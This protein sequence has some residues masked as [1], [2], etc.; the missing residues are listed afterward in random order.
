MLH[1]FFPWIKQ[2][3]AIAPKLGFTCGLMSHRGGSLESI[4]NTLTGFRKSAKLDVDLLEMDIYMTKDGQCVVF[5]DSDL[6]RLCGLPGKK[7]SDFEYRDLPP[8]LV[9][10]ALRSIESELNSD[11]DARRIP[12]FEQ[13]LKE[14]PTYPMQ[15]DVKEGSEEMVI[16]VGNLIKSYK[17]ES[18]TVWGSFRHPQNQHCTKHH[19]SIPLFFS[20]PRAALSYTL[21]YLGVPHWMRYRES[22]LI[23][24][25]HPWLLKR[26][27]FEDLNRMG[28][29]VI[30]WGRGR[31]GG[32]PGGGVNTV[33]KFERILQSGANGICTDRPTL[34]K[35]W[36]KD[37][38]LDKVDRFVT[39]RNN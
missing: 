32:G 19:P 18:T 38:P 15:V 2:P 5:H 36:L 21:S 28:I 1:R 20:F 9:P 14:F 25:D 35:E 8:L 17:K 33:E 26:W 39:K 3:A 22:A 16:K 29:N 24:P 6:G 10:S 30:V 31:D 12:L 34:L 13:V 27:W 11:A 4:E 23:V 37:N 7:I